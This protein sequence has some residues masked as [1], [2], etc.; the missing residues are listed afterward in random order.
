MAWTSPRTVRGLFA[1][2]RIFTP[3]LTNFASRPGLRWGWCLRRHSSFASSPGYGSVLGGCKPTTE[4]AREQPREAYEMPHDVLLALA[5]NGDESAREERMVREI[6]AVDGLSWDEAQP[7]LETI[8]A[9]NKQCGGP[10]NLVA[11]TYYKTLAVVS[12]QE[13]RW[14]GT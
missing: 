4:D 9:A 12:T 8:R 3:V 5:A 14:F 2:G 6:M 7:T 10:R 11:K 1:S 13:A